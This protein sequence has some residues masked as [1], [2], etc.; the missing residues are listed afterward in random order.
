M[1]LEITIK[2]SSGFPFVRKHDKVGEYSITDNKETQRCFVYSAFIFYSRAEAWHP[3]A[4]LFFP[5]CAVGTP[6]THPRWPLGGSALSHSTILRYNLRQLYILRN[7]S[8]REAA[9]SKEI[10]IWPQ[11]VTS[12]A[13]KG[14]HIDRP[15]WD[16]GNPR[17]ST[18]D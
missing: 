2:N 3:C 14:R 16:P 17:F 9:C 11:P 13:Q 5:K 6:T 18:I 1:R 4:R 7:K 10:G 8:S 12:R 15:T